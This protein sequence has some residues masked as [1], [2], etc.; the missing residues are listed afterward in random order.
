MSGKVPWSCGSQPSA[1]F[2][3]DGTLVAIEPP[4]RRAFRKAVALAGL[5]V[6]A[7]YLA[8]RGLYTLNPDALAF[9]LAVYVA[10]VHGFLFLALFYFQIWEV[11]QRTVPPAPPGFP[12]D[13]FITTFDEDVDL[14]RQTVRAALRMRYPHRTLV[15][16]AG[17]RAEVSALCDELGCEYVAGSAD[18]QTKAGPWND[19]FARTSGAV[20]AVFDAEHVP[21]ADFLDR[22]LGYF[23]DPA[24]GLVQ[25]PQRRLHADSLRERVDWRQRCIYAEHEVIR[26]LVMPGR[27]YWN[28]ST[29]WGSTAVLRRAALVP[30]GGL[31]SGTI[32]GDLHTSLVLQA[33]GWTSVYLNELLVTSSVPIDVSN[34]RA[35]RLRHAEGSLAIF[36]HVN[37][38]TRRGL[39]FAQRVCSVASMSRWTTCFPKLVFCLAPPLVLFSGRLPIAHLDRTF[40]A[41]FVAHLLSLAVS[42][43]VLTHGRSLLWMDELFHLSN[44]PLLLE[45]PARFVFGTRRS[46]IAGKRN[47]DHD[48]RA[49]LLHY[50]RIGCTVIA[51]VWGAL[52]LAF[53]VNADL[54]GTGL[55]G[56][57]ALH[58]LVL[59]AIVVSSAG[60]TPEPRQAV[61]FHVTTPVELL[62]VPAN[63][64]LGVTADLAETGCT[65]LWPRGLPIGPRLKLRLHLGAQP[66]DCDGEVVSV[67][68][69]VQ[70]DWVGHAIRFQFDCKTGVDR[71]ADALYNLTVPEASTRPTETSRMIRAARTTLG[72]IAGVTRFRAPRYEAHLPIRAQTR[73]WLAT[74]RDFS[75]GGLSVFSPSAVDPGRV[76]RVILRSPEGEWSS[77]ATVVRRTAL[78]AADEH[79]RMW[80][81]GLRVDLETDL[82]RLRHILSVESAL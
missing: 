24:V 13:V 51:L 18:E 5:A 46:G 1:R 74:T 26:N 69:R 16:D 23:A 60:R 49:I 57:W 73:E 76:V 22:T 44:I 79:F 12:V 78:P 6:Y 43:K 8:Y 67:S 80:L 38:F 61:R 54:A 9:S 81:L 55:A 82:V 32:A 35:D 36:R 2:D 15:V 4:A 56:L 72:R 25:V 39:T 33:D 17:R 45:A 77:L 31:F 30:H 14:L 63:G 3:A 59:L 40:A 19:A 62:D 66:L 42:V 11:R 70:G 10:E 75:H 28:A 20:I 37:P 21:R 68:A 48:G 71:L 65:L 53:G 50:A 64:W 7:G 47:G 29:L 58:N 41:V 34:D 52:G 27:D